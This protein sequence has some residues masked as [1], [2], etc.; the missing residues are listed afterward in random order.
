MTA[1]MNILG[2]EAMRCLHGGDSMGNQMR[3]RTGMSSQIE[4][5]PIYDSNQVAGDN[6][7]YGD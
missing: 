3:P 5:N 4:N 6:P 1:R 2:D 7:L